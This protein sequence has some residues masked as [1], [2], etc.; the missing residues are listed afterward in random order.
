MINE[1]ILHANFFIVGKFYYKIRNLFT[2]LYLLRLTPGQGLLVV[3]FT[4]SVYQKI[5]IVLICIR[6]TTD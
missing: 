1:N 4:A 5:D 6:A 3:I 2:Q